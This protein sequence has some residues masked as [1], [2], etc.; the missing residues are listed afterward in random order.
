[1]DRFTRLNQFDF[2]HALQETRGVSLVLFTSSAC[3]ACRAWRGVLAGYRARNPGVSVFEVDCEQEMA[4]VR[5]FEVYHLPAIFLY[6]D[7]VYHCQVQCDAQLA[8]LRDCITDLL[9]QPPQDLP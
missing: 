4:L 6:R 1:M 5:E 7:G 3:G 2:H 9:Q 8:T